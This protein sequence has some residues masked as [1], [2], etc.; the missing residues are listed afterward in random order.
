VV[1]PFARLPRKAVDEVTREGVD[2]LQRVDPASGH[3][4]EFS[5]AS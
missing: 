5:A 1:T 4:V 3:E 2:L